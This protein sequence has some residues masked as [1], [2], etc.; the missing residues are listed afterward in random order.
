MSLR[1][2]LVKLAYANPSLRKDLL[3]LVKRAEKLQ[4]ELAVDADP[5]SKDQNKPETYYGLEPKGLQ[6]SKLP[7]LADLEGALIKARKDVFNDNQVIADAA[8][9]EIKRLRKLI[10]NHPDE[11]S[12]RDEVRRKENERFM[13]RWE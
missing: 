7:S 3:P 10:E 12:R 13:R 5:E 9:L 2:A 4:S 11:V 8:S 6:A 1:S